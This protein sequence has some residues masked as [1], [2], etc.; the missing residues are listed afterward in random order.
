M[1]QTRMIE[2][3]TIVPGR[4]SRDPLFSLAVGCGLQHVDRPLSTPLAARA[5]K[6]GWLTMHAFTL[7]LIC[8]S[9]R[10]VA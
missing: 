8:L 9:Q 1:P 5:R 10:Y 7:E 4:L 2:I 6:R 3:V